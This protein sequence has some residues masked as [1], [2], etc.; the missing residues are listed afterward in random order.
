MQRSRPIDSPRL[1]A[2]R[3]RKPSGRPCKHT[4]RQY[5]RSFL[6]W[7]GVCL[8]LEGVDRRPAIHATG[9]TYPRYVFPLVN[10]T[11]ASTSSSVVVDCYNS[12]PRVW[13][14]QHPP[15]EAL[16]SP[17][18][19]FST[20]DPPSSGSPRV[21]QSSGDGAHQKRSR[22]HSSAFRRDARQTSPRIDVTY[23]F[24]YSRDWF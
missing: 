24:I 10:L 6:E 11:R 13:A 21:A 7:I 17:S 14:L 22:R 4:T 19:I 3:T 1:D 9:K 15:Q 5:P 18:A 16:S 23:D 12:P 20:R 8:T 2:A